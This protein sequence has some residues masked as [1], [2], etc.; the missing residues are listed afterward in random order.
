MGRKTERLSYPSTNSGD[1]SQRVLTVS[2]TREHRSRRE[3][4]HRSASP[5]IHTVRGRPSLRKQ[6]KGAQT[7]DRRHAIAV[8]EGTI[9]LGLPQKL[10]PTPLLTTSNDLSNSFSERFTQTIMS[11]KIF[12]STQTLCNFL[13]SSCLSVFRLL[14]I[15]SFAF[16]DN[17]EKTFFLFFHNI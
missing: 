10:R 11:K 16:W 6:I 8:N 13:R 4:F 5:R 9:D 1:D 7:N 15:R 2:F 17:R 14:R 12:H 3:S